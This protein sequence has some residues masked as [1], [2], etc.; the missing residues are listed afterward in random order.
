MNHIY[1]SL[2]ASVTELKRNPGAIIRA[3]GE[4]AVAILNHN[5]PAAYL[6]PVTVYEAMLDRLD[7]VDLAETVRQRVGEK[8]DA[9]EV[10]LDEL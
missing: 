2:S 8:P 10:T 9:V 4:T 6:V 3:A 1:S 5:R 7:D